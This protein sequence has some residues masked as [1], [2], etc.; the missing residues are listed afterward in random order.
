[1]ADESHVL[2]SSLAFV[3]AFLGGLIRGTK[4]D[5]Q[6]RMKLSALRQGYTWLKR[7]VKTVARATKVPLEEEPFLD[8]LDEATDPGRRL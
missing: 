2:M 6:V 3:G 1:M 8:A 5:P 4:L 7:Q